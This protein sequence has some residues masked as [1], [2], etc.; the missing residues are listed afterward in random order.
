M[1]TVHSDS[2]FGFL[3]MRV[4]E[5]TLHVGQAVDEHRK[6][7]SAYYTNNETVTE[8]VSH[9]EMNMKSAMQPYVETDHLSRMERRE[10]KRFMRHSTSSTGTGG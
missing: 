9:A 4:T 3:Q 1:T 10:Y 5:H 7:C 8:K 2:A 6:S